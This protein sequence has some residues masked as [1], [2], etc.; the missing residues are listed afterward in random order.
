MSQQ[1]KNG[2]FERGYWE[3]HSGA[4]RSQSF[5]WTKSLHQMSQTV[6]KAVTR[7]TKFDIR[8]FISLEQS[9]GYNSPICVLLQTRR[10]TWDSALSS[11]QTVIPMILWQCICSR[12]YSFNFS[13]IRLEVSR[14]FSTSRMVVLL[15]TRTSRTS[16]TCAIMKMILMYQQIGMFLQPPMEKAHLMELEELLNALQLEL[17]SNDL[18]ISRLW[19]RGSSMNFLL[20]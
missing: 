14:R 8:G 3:I 17:V 16:S 1:E 12:N 20:K 15:S 7:I 2:W 10:K 4:P 19:P 18:W 9:P 11:S 6:V 13:L 5:S